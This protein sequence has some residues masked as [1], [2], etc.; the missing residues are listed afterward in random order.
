MDPSGAITVRIVDTDA[1]FVI[2]QVQI[3]V[4]QLH[5]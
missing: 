4:R 5:T 2:S 1:V 3:S